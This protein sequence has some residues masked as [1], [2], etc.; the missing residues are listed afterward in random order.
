[1]TP[2]KGFQA[3]A[4]SQ[5][6]E[7]NR[8][9]NISYEKN[10][11]V[12]DIIGKDTNNR[13]GLKGQ[14]E[15]M[16]VSNNETSGFQGVLLQNR[17]NKQYF[18]SMRGTEFDT[19]SDNMDNLG[20]AFDNISNQEV[21]ANRLV[22]QSLDKITTDNQKIKTR[23]EAKSYLTLT[24][25]SK[26]GGIAQLVAEK[27]HIKAVTFNPFGARSLLINGIDCVNES[28]IL[29]QG[30]CYVA[31]MVERIK[32]DTKSIPTPW[33]DKGNIINF[34]SEKDKVSTTITDT[35]GGRMGTYV[36]LADSSNVIKAHKND[37]MHKLLIKHQGEQRKCGYKTMEEAALA[38]RNNKTQTC[39]APMHH[40]GYGMSF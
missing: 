21:D 20:M 4:E 31:T 27:Q 16:L 36:V 3:Y 13:L 33:A 19:L 11:K 6:T 30:V 35:F 24:G 40:A 23:E 34:I 32:R 28:N 8:I 38:I 39:E 22:E 2:T 9:S 17:D 37:H 10:L 12:G 7:F 26:G 18:V 5:S 25:H 14:Y 1:M 15:V 29:K